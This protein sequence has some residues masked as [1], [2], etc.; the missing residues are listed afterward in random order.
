VD[1]KHR[2]DA[3]R[4]VALVVAP[5]ILLLLA[6]G[7]GPAGDVGGSSSG[8]AGAPGAG[9]AALAEAF[10]DR[11]SDLEVEGDGTVDRL[12]PDDEEGSRH[13]RFIL[14]L[15]SGQTLLV[16][17]NIEIAPRIAGL[18][19]GD[20]VTFRG[21][22]EWNPEGGTIHWTHHDPSSDHPA[23]WLRHGGRVYE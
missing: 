1:V 13:Q 6:G 15:A 9:D 18:H 17:H 14:R 20:L 2:Q 7:C 8:A 5:A 12:L 11:A 10:D 19:A 16:A 3:A 21:V 23:G 4:L 22:Y